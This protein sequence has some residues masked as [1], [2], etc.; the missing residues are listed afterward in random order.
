MNSTE[1]KI[2]ANYLLA[3]FEGEMQTT[4]NVLAAAPDASLDYRPDGKSKTALGLLRHLT[5]E[6][7]WLLNS[8]ADGAFTPP[9][10]DS[11]ACGI[12]NAAD[13]VSRYK[14][15]VPAAVERVRGLPAERLIESID[16]FGMFQ[17]P[18]LGFLS[19]TAK[20]SIHHR[21][22]LT[23]YLRAMGGKVPSVYGPTADSQQ[24]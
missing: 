14:A 15:T 19:I 2:I 7:A 1:A 12:H 3:D 10:D 5:L 8:I 18:A 4:I 17:L 21:G 13:A 22:Q 9:P 24:G 6:D 23:S 16:M 11:D 20:H